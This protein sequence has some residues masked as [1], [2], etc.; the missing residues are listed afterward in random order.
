MARRNDGEIPLIDDDDDG[1]CFADQEVEQRGFADVGPADDGSLDDIG[2]VGWKKGGGKPRP[3]NGRGV[4]RRI[5][6]SEGGIQEIVDSS[7]VLGGD[8]KDGDADA[9]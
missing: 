9:M 2:F 3:Y 6:F 7:A 8:G 4:S 5:E 1:A